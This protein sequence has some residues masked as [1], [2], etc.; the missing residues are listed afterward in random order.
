VLATLLDILLLLLLLASAV[1]LLRF[2][3]RLSFISRENT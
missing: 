2:P 3:V 1:A